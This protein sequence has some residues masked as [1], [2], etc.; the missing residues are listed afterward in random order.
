[1]TL[2]KWTKHKADLQLDVPNV[3]NADEAAVFIDVS[4]VRLRNGYSV[5]VDLTLRISTP[6]SSK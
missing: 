6:S 2:R 5:N 4:K 3:S 1:M